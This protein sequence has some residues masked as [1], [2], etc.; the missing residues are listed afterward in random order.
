MQRLDG[1]SAVPPPLRGAIVALGNFDG[2]HFGHQAVVGRALERARAE[3]RPAIVATFDPHPRRFF[4]PDAPPFRLTTLDQRERLFATAGAA[5]MLVFH[6]DATL[7]RLTARQFAEQLVDTVGAAGVVTGEDFTFGKG[8][9]GDVAML[10]ALG[11]ELGFA[12]E[13][14]A[15]VTLDDTTVSSSRIRALL[16]AGD[17]RGAARLLTRPFA[18]AAEVE[19]GARLG[20][21]LGY[22][23]ANMR[24]GNYLRPRYGIY[25][26]RGR[27][28]DGR[29]LNGVAN[30]GIRP[31][32]DPPTELL[33]S[34]F[35]DF[36]G[37][38]YGQTVEVALIEYLR[39]EAKFDSLAALTAQMDQD[40]A[41]ARALLAEP[42]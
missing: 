18:I 29:L 37:D 25:A 27:L 10:A 5:G 38:L 39:P 2:F 40:A 22:P 16:Q 9:E 20:R 6:F 14:V 32:F 35:F 11:A 34:F 8:R 17:P 42:A 13:T 15:P 28:A 7:A 41:R 33:E 12:A 4:Q 36:S 26:V 3:G 1:G 24:L 31:S 21:Q 19:G 23:T 30:L